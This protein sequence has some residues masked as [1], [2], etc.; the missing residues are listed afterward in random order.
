MNE[1]VHRSGLGRRAWGLGG[2]CLG[3]ILIVAGCASS[4]GGESDSGEKTV[5][6]AAEQQGLVTFDTLEAK[7]VAGTYEYRGETVHFESTANEHGSDI[8]LGMRGMVLTATLDSSGA[9]EVDGYKDADGTDTAMTAMDRAL[10]HG[11]E[12]ALTDLYRKRAA[13]LP[14]LDVLSRSL[15][16]WS[17]YPDTVP[18]RRTFLARDERRGALQ[19]LCGNV[20]KVGQGGNFA[21]KFTWA[22]HD[23]FK[24]KGV[25]TTD[26]GPLSGGCAYGN[27]SST[28][29]NVFMS[30]HPN[31]SCDGGTYFGF[32]STS[33]LCWAQ[34]HD[35]RAEWGYGGCF[36]RCGDSCGGATQFTQA[37]LD[38]DLCVRSAHWSGTP[39][40]D[41]EFVEAAVDWASASNCGG[42]FRVDFNWAGSPN[43]GHCPTSFMNTNDGCDVGCQFIDGDC[44][45]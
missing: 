41:D 10:V 9:F 21:P 20:N 35:N 2:V 33:Q 8:T 22:S 26:C 43:E 1:L 31:G 23:C 44:F 14:A 36:G 24:I 34:D 32:T 5:V 17:E 4:H 29:E 19:S 37:C 7:R 13:E 39:G 27:D 38:H 15:T 40:C 42:E 6:V 30:M 11:F 28:V 16:M 12:V 18:L 25:F 3:A 45:R